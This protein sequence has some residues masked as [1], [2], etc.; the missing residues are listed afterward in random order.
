MIWNEMKW[1]KKKWI[2]LKKMNGTEM[3][4]ELKFEK[5]EWFEMKWSVLKSVM[6]WIE[7]WNRNEMK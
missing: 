6:K 3:W 4:N 5:N 2:V 7:I 1:S